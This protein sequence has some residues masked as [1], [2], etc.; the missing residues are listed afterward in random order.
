MKSAMLEAKRQTKKAGHAT[1]LL[2]ADLQLYRVCLNV[3]LA[4]PELFDEYLGEC[5]F[6]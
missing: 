6:L 3:Q 2:M 5:N 1:T 4:Y